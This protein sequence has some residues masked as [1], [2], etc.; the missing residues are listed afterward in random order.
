MS[1]HNLGKKVGKYV[2]TKFL[3]AG[4]FGQVY[5]CNNNEDGKEYACKLIEKKKLNN[6]ILHDML[7][8]E[9]AIMQ[10][11]H[12]R[13]VIHLFDFLQSGSNYYLIMQVCNNGDI[14]KYLEKIG[15]SH[16]DENEA[17]YFLQQISLGFKELHRYKVNFS[18]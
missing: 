16:F 13:N 10:K 9:V 5:L 15:K 14:R 4:Q 2:L 8:S 3:G 1:D 18:Y 7:K 11:I 12:H 17:V 6:P